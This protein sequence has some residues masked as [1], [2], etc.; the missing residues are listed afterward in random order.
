MSAVEG[1]TKRKKV[2]K[3][4]GAAIGALAAV[5][6]PAVVADAGKDFVFVRACSCSLC[7]DRPPTL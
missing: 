3:T 5:E 6:Q 4:L 7:S 2:L 1:R